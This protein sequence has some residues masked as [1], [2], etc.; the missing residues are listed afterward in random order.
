MQ[1]KRGFAALL[2]LLV[3]LVIA[4]MIYFL[5]IRAIFGPS[6]QYSSRPI[7]EE[8]HPWQMD[9][10]LIAEGKLVPPP[11]RGQPALVK[12][13]LL[14]G[15]VLRNDAPRG[16]VQI[17]IEK[18]CRIAGNWTTRYQDGTKS[19]SLQSQMKGNIVRDKIYSNADGEDPTRLYFFAKGVY[20][21]T[22]QLP[23]KTSHTEKGVAYMMGWLRPDYTATGTITITTD[24]SWSAQYPFTASVPKAS[25]H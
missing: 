23:D 18:N 15:N 7:Q 14:Q 11:R 22:V 21:Q 9:D 4:M 13:I 12:P 2:G 10:L 25:E 16:T 6:S 20:T 1:K 5:D 17:V 24:Q 19:Y 3:V 8:D